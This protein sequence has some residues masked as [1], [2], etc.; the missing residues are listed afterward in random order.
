[1]LVAQQLTAAQSKEAYK[2]IVVGGLLTMWIYRINYITDLLFVK[3]SIL[4][5][6]NHIASVHKS[7]HLIVRALM[8]IV[9]VSSFAMIMAGIFTCN[10]P[11]DAWSFTVFWNNFL[12]I[13]S[14][15]CYNPIILWYV[16]ASFNLF[17]DCVL[18]FLPIPF[19]LNLQTMPMR[20]RLELCGIFSIGIMAVVASAIRLWI[21]VIWTSSWNA[22]GEN[23]GNFLIWGQVEQ[24]AGIIAA[25]IP[26]LRPI[27][28]KLVSSR[29]RREQL[30]PGPRAKLVQQLTPEGNPIPPRTPII[31]S[32]SPTMGSSNSPF[33]A[34]ADP[35]SP[36]EPIQAEL[37][38]GLSVG[39][40]L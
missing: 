25:S 12:G 1:M 4:L 23:M 6:Y 38:I 37:S 8:A 30:S 35:L 21:L 18:W 9:V 11:S 16:N 17:T 34:P 36:I 31:P 15:Q 28:R 26:F 14:T 22:E 20:R 29:H 7:F 19:F 27:Y 32:P 33:R 40:A 39:R 3:L 2:E 5:F 13:Y 24:H 10:P